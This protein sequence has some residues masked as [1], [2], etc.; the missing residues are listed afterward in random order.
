MPSFLFQF[1]PNYYKHYGSAEESHTQAVVRFLQKLE[2]ALK[3]QASPRPFLGGVEGRASAADYL[4]WPWL[5]RLE[6][7]ATITDC[8]LWESTLA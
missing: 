1:I 4:I 8:K 7:I 2:D 6:A 5:E 3:E